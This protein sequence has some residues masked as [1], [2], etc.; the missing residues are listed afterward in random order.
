MC[1]KGRVQPVAIFTPIAPA[2]DV[3]PQ[4]QDELARWQ[5][6][7]CAYRAQDWRTCETVLDSLVERDVNKVLYRLYAQRL[8]SLKL[9]PKSPDWDGATRF[10]T[11]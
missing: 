6:V 8:A 1:V 2:A 9:L 5:K 7:L 4:Q 3:D 10:D 11:K